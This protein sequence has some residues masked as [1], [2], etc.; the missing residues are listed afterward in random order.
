MENEMMVRVER[1]VKKKK[2][3]NGKGGGWGRGEAAR[4]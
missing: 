4:R 2:K 3:W 1:R